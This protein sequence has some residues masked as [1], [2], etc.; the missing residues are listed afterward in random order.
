M[1]ESVL[2]CVMLCSTTEPVV[3]ASEIPRPVA[4]AAGSP[5]PVTW[6]PVIVMPE[7]PLTLIP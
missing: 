5:A 1:P 7:E 4:P 6:L 3:V 2:W